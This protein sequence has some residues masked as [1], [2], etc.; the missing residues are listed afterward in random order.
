MSTLFTM[1]AT[2]AL[3]GAIGWGVGKV[4]DV[5]TR[6]VTCNQRDDIR[7]GNCQYNDLECSNCHLH[8]NQ[9]TNACNA[10]IDRSSGSI[11]HVVI[12]KNGPDCK[13]FSYHWGGYMSAF[14]NL[15][16]SIP[17][18]VDYFVAI[19]Y[20]M[21]TCGMHGRTFLVDYRVLAYNTEQIL[22]SNSQVWSPH[23]I[24][25]LETKEWHVSVN[26][27][28]TG[29]PLLCDM[30]VSSEYKDHIFT[31]RRVFKYP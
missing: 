2:K 15:F 7:I 22:Y 14:T 19:P 9:F 6:C 12:R 11:G 17:K 31:H 4:L 29:V 16:T 27:I 25:S 18:E 3:D 5:A 1:F 13:S 8:I 30:I 28:P 24:R 20:A 26:Q 10:T 23:S 21:E